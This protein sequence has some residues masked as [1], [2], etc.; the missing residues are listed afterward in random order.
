MPNNL[1]NCTI[2]VKFIANLAAHTLA[3]WSLADGTT[4]SFNLGDGPPIVNVM[5]DEAG[6]S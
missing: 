6:L 5:Q 3:T 4:G 2:L 1:E